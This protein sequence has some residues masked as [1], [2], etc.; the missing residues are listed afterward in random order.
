VLLAICGLL[1]AIT[2]RR[3]RLPRPLSEQGLLLGGAWFLTL[4]LFF[5]FAL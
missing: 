3:P 2:W 4:L 5:S 1:V